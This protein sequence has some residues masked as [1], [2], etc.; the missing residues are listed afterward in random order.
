MDCEGA[1]YEILEN[2]RSMF[3]QIGRIL[4]ETHTISDRAAG[5]L[6]ELLRAHAFDVQL[7]SG[8]RLYAANTLYRATGAV[9]ASVPRSAVGIRLK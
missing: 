7:F 9:G 3:Q 1:E 5:D 6:E 8:S 2:A 4:M